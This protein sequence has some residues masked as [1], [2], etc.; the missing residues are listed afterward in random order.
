VTSEDKRVALEEVFADGRRAGSDL[1]KWSGDCPYP[2]GGN[3]QLRNKWFDGFGAGRAILA[4][5]TNPEGDW[6]A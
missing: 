1:T 4:R 6:E 3:I 2:P 5:P